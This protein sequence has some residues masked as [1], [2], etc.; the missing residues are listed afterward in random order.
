MHNDFVSHYKSSSMGTR[1]PL[2]NLLI[3]LIMGL[4]SIDKLRRSSQECITFLKVCIFFCLSDS[5]LCIQSPKK[6][7]L[8]CISLKDK[9]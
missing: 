6:E 5:L 7:L 4:F 1:G 3:F 8:Y 9:L 2:Q